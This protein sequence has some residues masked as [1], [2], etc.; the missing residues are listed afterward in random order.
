MAKLLPWT[1]VL[2]FLAT[3]SKND[4]HSAHEHGDHPASTE[5]SKIVRAGDLQIVF[6]LQSIADR[7]AMLEMMKLPPRAAGGDRHLSLTVL[8]ARSGASLNSARVE[9]KIEGPDGQLAAPVYVMAG[10][11]MHHWGADFAVKTKGRYTMTATVA[12]EGL[13]EQT[14]TA[15]FEIR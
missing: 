3:C 15:E 13:A 4:E 5:T 2:L 10:E 8:N 6:D 14:A 7:D 11:G 1:F 12:A 9:V